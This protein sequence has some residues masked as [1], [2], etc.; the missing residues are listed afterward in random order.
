MNHPYQIHL[1]QP[2]WETLIQSL[3]H[4]D[5]NRQNKINAFFNSINQ[6]ITIRYEENRS[7]IQSDLLDEDAILAALYAPETEKRA[8]GGN[9]YCYRIACSSVFDE[10]DSYQATNNPAEYDGYRELLI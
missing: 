6:D 10:Q 4:V 7:V 8:I 5:N 3:T 9:S 1:A 2:E